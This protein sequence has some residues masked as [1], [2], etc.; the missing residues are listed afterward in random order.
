MET[1]MEEDD[2]TAELLRDRFRLSAISIAEAEAKRSG[3][4]I[5]VPVMTCVAELAFK[6][7]KQLAKDL[8]LFAHHG[9]RKSVNTEDVILSAHRNEHLAAS[10]SSFCHELKTKEPQSERK[11]KKAPKK[12]DKS[13]IHITDA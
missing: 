5:S 4:E 2:S 9:G 6:Y 8:E 7:T 13:A 10:L 12:E 1:G 3:M 11:R